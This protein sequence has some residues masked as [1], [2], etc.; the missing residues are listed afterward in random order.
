MI[1]IIHREL[2]YTVF[3]ICEAVASHGVK[4]CNQGVPQHILLLE[5]ISVTPVGELLK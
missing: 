5:Y 4:L 2:I 1:N 3:N